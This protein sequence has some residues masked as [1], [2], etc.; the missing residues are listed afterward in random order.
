MTLYV[1][2]VCMYTTGFAYFGSFFDDGVPVEE[3]WMNRLNSD[4]FSE[5]TN[6]QTSYRPKA[7]R[8]NMGEF[9]MFENTIMLQVLY[10]T[11]LFRYM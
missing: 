2:V 8:Y 7:Q 10:C 3:T 11:V 1:R 6:L 5:L 9:S 4:K